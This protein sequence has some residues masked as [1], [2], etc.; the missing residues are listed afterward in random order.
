LP[1]PQEDYLYPRT[2]QPA[3]EQV[4]GIRVKLKH[5]SEEKFFNTGKKKEEQG[6]IARSSLISQTVTN[7]YQNFN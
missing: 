5:L 1:K 7:L 6:L 3:L 2:T 4:S